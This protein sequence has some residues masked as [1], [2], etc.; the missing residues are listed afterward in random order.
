MSPGRGMLHDCYP[1]PF[2]SGLVSGKFKHIK[3][4]FMVSILLSDKA[5]SPVVM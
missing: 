3:T 2:I 5:S 4:D 1:I